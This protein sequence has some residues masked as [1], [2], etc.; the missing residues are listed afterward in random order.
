MN[1]RARI[2]AMRRASMEQ[3]LDELEQKEILKYPLE[4]TGSG[5][6][7]IVFSLLREGKGEEKERKKRG[8][9]FKVRREYVE[10]GILMDDLEKSGMP[11]R[12]YSG[13]ERLR[14]FME[15][16][17]EHAR[18]FYE[19]LGQYFP[20]HTL[21]GRHAEVTNVPVGVQL[22][23][24]IRTKHGKTVKA[25]TKEMIVPGLVEVQ[26]RIMKEAADDAQN[27]YSLGVRYAEKAD[28]AA[29]DYGRLNEMF[30]DQ[31]V[32]ADLDAIMPYLHA[33]TQEMLDLAKED[34]ELKEKMAEFLENAIRFS[35]DQDEL[36]DLVGGGNVRFFKDENDKWDY[37]LVDVFAPISLSDARASL[38]NVR[39][40][41]RSKEASHTDVLNAL[42]FV[43]GMNALAMALG[44]NER[45]KPFREMRNS[46]E[47]SMR[48][49]SDTLFYSIRER[50]GWL[51]E[52]DGELDDSLLDTEV[53]SLT[54][55]LD[56]QT[57]NHFL[58]I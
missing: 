56:N 26:E 2:E 43:R 55:I 1:E 21:L 18:M 20:P 5:G 19:G 12:A 27:V 50:Y 45:I 8:V 13:R 30:L 14:A 39:P 4:Y 7:N 28:M 58:H 47:G 34:A 51:P 11:N 48:E 38:R 6:A 29:D 57:M 25:Q 17:M 31:T 9:V 41:E 42:N 15:E 46:G 10:H 54:G 3:N 53:R 36:L 37:L 44:I 23:N 33:G 49:V 32:E 16:E 22:A 52:I 40:F 35:N 24:Q